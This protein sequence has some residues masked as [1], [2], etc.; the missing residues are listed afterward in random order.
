M[1]AG[2]GTPTQI[3]PGHQRFHPGST[4]QKAPCFLWGQN[5]FPNNPLGSHV[6]WI[7]AS[8]ACLPSQIH[9]PATSCHTADFPPFFPPQ[10]ARQ[11]HSKILHICKPQP[12]TG[13]AGHSLGA[14]RSKH[15]PRSAAGHGSRPHFHSG[16]PLVSGDD[17]YFLLMLPMEKQTH[18]H[19]PL[20]TAP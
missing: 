5:R 10:R 11:S 3:H 16:M 9:T 19:T 17:G 8:G 6:F 2:V 13:P 1:K 18:T 4:R 20:L 7:S 15:L 12:A 14:T